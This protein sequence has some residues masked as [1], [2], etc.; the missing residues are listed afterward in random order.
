MNKLSSFFDPFFAYIDTG[1]IF[2]KPF[3]WLYGLIAVLNAVFPFIIL[4]WIIDSG[5][6]S[7]L[8]AKQIFGIILL[9]LV[10]LAAGWFSFQLWW[11]RL[12]KVSQLTCD[13]ADFAVTPAFAHLLQ[14]FGEWLGSYIAI[15]G[16][17]SA[18]FSWL[19]IDPSIL[20]HLFKISGFGIFTL[21]I[22]GI[23][24][25]PI[26]GFLV[27]VSFRFA[28]EVARALASIANNTKK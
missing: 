10:M 25:A 6:F 9:W 16:T 26:Y 27:F 7:M 23:F 21:G 13:N 19:L 1:K 4:Y 15:V 17:F 22:S 14:T 11:N 24:I 28:A 2:R 20:G 5:L 3:S 18:L 12:A 8:A